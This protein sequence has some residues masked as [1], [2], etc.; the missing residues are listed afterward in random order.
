MRGGGTPIEHFHQL[1][2][3]IHIRSP[4]VFTSHRG[5]Y[6]M[7]TGANVAG[8]APPSQG[9][10]ARAIGVL[11]SPRRTYAG[12]AARPRALGVLVLTVLITAGA[13]VVFFSTAVGKQTMLEQQVK[14]MESFGVKIPDAA[15]Q[16][17]E[18]RMSRPATPYV[19][20]AFQVVAAPVILLI[21]SGIAIAIFNAVLG[22][23]ATFKQVFATVAHSG[24]IT[25]VQTL[26]ALPLDYVRESLTSP[27]S[28]AVFAPFL[29]DTSFA[30]RFLSGVDLFLL[31]WLVNLAIGLGVLY[32]RRTGPIAIGLLVA[33]LS[34][35][36]LVAA[37]R[38]ALSGA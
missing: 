17:M 29:E 8:A 20:A 35:V 11:V 18:E 33:Y 13:S 12:V 1:C 14:T 15:Y 23:E 32:K 5:V 21:I 10:L 30:S 36:F 2:R 16:Q 7:E 22:G 37:L 3:L 6:M 19:T 31:W 34:I 9:L 38:T 25:T 26:F 4:R 27:T 28:L 24:V